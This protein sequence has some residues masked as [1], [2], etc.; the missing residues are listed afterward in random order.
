[1]IAA[2]AAAQLHSQLHAH[3]EHEV[4]SFERAGATGIE[5]YD[6]DVADATGSVAT[7]VHPAARRTGSRRKRAATNAVNAT[8]QGEQSR[9]D[10]N[11]SG[12]I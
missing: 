6:H 12:G 9:T 1:V 5:R 8:T 2:M 10:N 4:R 7:S 11:K 3:D